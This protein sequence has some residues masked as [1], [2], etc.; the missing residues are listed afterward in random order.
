MKEFEGTI[1]MPAQQLYYLIETAVE[2]ALNRQ[3]ASNSSKQENETL[4]AEEAAKELKYKSARTLSKY[5][6]KG[7]TPTR[8]GRR[9]FYKREEVM[10]LKL[11][12]F[13][14]I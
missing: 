1:I 6:H 12:I 13:N 7:L 5:H 3:G 9:I 14:K 8:R 11:N 4:T 10:Q 2:T